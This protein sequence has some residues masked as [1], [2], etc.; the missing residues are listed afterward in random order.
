MGG[1]KFPT[2]RPVLRLNCKPYF[3]FGSKPMVLWALV[4]AI[5]FQG[6]RIAPAAEDRMGETTDPGLSTVITEY[7]ADQSAIDQTYDLPASEQDIARR[8]ALLR[9]WQE[10]L[11]KLPYDPLSAAARIDWHLLKTHLKSGLEE[12][13]LERGRLAEMQPLLSFRGPLLKLLTARGARRG[14]DP[15]KA[16]QM[17][18]T[19]LTEVKS[20]RK[21]LDQG[22]EKEPPAES[23][24]PS[25]VLAQRSAST[26]DQLR[27][28]VGEWFTFYDGFQP[29]FGWWVRQP[30]AALAKELEDLSGYLRREVAGLKG[31]DDDPLIGDPIGAA[32]LISQL[33]TECIPYTPEELV[34]LAGKEFA[35]CEAEMAKAAAAMGCATAAEALAKVKELHARPGGQPSVAVQEARKAIQFLKDHELVTIPPLAEETWRLSMLGVAQQ[36]SLPYAV[37]GA[38][39]MMIAYAHES[40][41]Q[42]DKMMSMRGNNAAFL[43]IVTPHELIPG[44]HLQLFQSRRFSTQRQ[45][46]RTPFLV[47]GWALHWEMLLWDQGYAA[48]PEEKI[49]ALFWRLHRC[50]R[51]IVS[52]KFHLGE[53]TPAQMIDFLV[54]RVGHE[55]SG[56]TAEVRRYIGG[57]YGPLY[58]AAYMLGGM[59]LRALHQSLTGPDAGGDRLTERQF[60]DAVLREGPVPIEFIRAALTHQSLPKEWTSS[61][62]FSEGL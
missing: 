21:K 2:P 38:P 42:E 40:M 33:G 16:A 53:M 11:E 19:A 50:A 20:V 55:R 25:P 46:F 49:G 27:R 15:E 1:M 9:E 18:A 59:Q 56:A 36:K 61:W 34:A 51:I 7:S 35:W 4:V 37:Y 57:A 8:E 14:V 22:K 60:H 13:L 48:T 5:S 31:E 30:H 6:I 12:L 24:K 26:L 62:R 28:A 52:L 58:Q 3:C 39:H 17:L 43:H 41:P 10:K 47:E 23:L 44:H 45:L 32:A 29:D 54:Q